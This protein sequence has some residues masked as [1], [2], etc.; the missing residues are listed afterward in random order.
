MDQVYG[1]DAYM[2]QTEKHLETQSPSN[3]EVCI[4]CPFC[5]HIVHEF[6]SRCPWCNEEW[7]KLRDCY[8]RS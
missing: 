5:G 2:Q 1:N 8:L 7:E 4:E 6:A 3:D